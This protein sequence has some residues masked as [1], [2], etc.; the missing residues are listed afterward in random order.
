[1]SA[2]ELSELIIR[3]SIVLYEMFNSNDCTL[4]AELIDGR[5]GVDGTTYANIGTAIR[6]QFANVEDDVNKLKENIKEKE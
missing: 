2:E 4:T 6:T 5:I 1:M 3:S